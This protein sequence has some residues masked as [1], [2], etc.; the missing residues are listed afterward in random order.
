MSDD[1]R[2]ADLSKLKESEMTDAQ[3]DELRRRF[4][5]FVKNVWTAG[6][7]TPAPARAPRNVKRWMP[8]K[9]A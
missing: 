3:R 7:R 5:H 2:Q 9:R 8:T 6:R 1:L 4:Q